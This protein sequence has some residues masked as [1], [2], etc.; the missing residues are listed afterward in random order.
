MLLKFVN[1]LVKFQ[2]SALKIGESPQEAG[3]R[4]LIQM[5]EMKIKVGKVLQ[6]LGADFQELG[7][8]LAILLL[9][10]AEGIA[11]AAVSVAKGVLKIGQGFVWLLKR[12]D[13]IGEAIFA[14][15]S[16]FAT[17]FAVMKVTTNFGLIAD[18]LL[19]V[20]AA[21]KGISVLS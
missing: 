14:F 17:A 19:K 16:T 21:L 12:I 7:K 4:L 8:E 2:D 3:A 5:N 15:G 11:I 18:G 6:G 9:P 10:L 1:S 13:D 20:Q